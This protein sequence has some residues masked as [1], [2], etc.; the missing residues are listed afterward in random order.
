VPSIGGEARKVSAGNRVVA[1]PSGK[2]LLISVL[3]STNMR[4]F[5]VPLDGTPETEVKT[6]AAD[7]VRYSYLSPGS[8]SA[9]GR[10]LISLHNTWFSAPAILDT[11]T[12]RVHPLPFDGA[13]DYIS[14]AWLPDGRMVALRLGE[15]ST[16]WRFTPASE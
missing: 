13:S 12:G 11:H 10:L 6:N 8:V 1:D 16:L 14:M 4:L 7:A 9:D 3:E 2:A 15:N 5:R